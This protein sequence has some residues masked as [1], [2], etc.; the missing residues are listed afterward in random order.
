[1]S[2]IL[3]GNSRKRFYLVLLPLSLSAFFSF[4]SWI[5]HPELTLQK[6]TE[7]PDGDFGLTQVVRVKNTSREYTASTVLVEGELGSGDELIV[8]V[9]LI[10]ELEAGK[11][12][13]PRVFLPGK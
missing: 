2:K 12:R 9:V 7:L 5:Q 13:T 8:K 11:T 10:G 3:K 1:M 6:Q 4:D